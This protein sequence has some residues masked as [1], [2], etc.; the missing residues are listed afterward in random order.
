MLSIVTNA[1]T[2]DR[3]AIALLTNRPIHIEICQHTEVLI[4][5]SLQ[6]FAVPIVDGIIDLG[7][8]IA[9]SGIT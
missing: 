3:F 5:N 6:S 1:A 7:I 9:H 4:S 8:R 2:D